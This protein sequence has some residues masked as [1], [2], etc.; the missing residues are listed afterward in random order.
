MQYIVGGLILIFIIKLASDLFSSYRRP[1]GKSSAKGR[2]IDISEQWINVDS[3]PYRRVETLM[4]PSEL[5]FYHEIE[6]ILSEAP[7]RVLPKIP[8]SEI[9]SIPGSTN[10]RLEYY[11]RAQEK[12]LD[13]VIFE[14]PEY[15]PRVIII[16]QE[17]TISKKQQLSETFT[18]KAVEAAGYAYMKININEV[19][20]PLKVAQSLRKL[21]IS[22]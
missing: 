10:N 3:L 11:R 21:G 15:T 17:A 18:E 19:P 9:I 2:I 7:Y 13:L 16:L 8:L 6:N 12:N 22:V 14:M 1:H 20:D 4:S 5:A